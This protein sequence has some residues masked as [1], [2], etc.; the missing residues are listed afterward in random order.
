MRPPFRNLLT[1]SNRS[2][3]MKWTHHVLL[4]G[5][6]LA[7]GGAGMV[8]H[9]ALTQTLADAQES[10]CRAENEGLDELGCM[11]LASIGTGIELAWGGALL[12]AGFLAAAVAL[13]ARARPQRS[14]RA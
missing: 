8:A 4:A 5:L 7:I 6:V 9:A 2:P 3:R 10:A 14:A 1:A 11:N 12:L 13:L